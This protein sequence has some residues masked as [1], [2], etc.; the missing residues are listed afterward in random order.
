M[1]NLERVVRDVLDDLKE[2]YKKDSE[3]VWDAPAIRLVENGDN[4]AYV[5]AMDEQLIDRLRAGLSGGKLK[6]LVVG[7][8]VAKYSDKLRDINGQPQILERAILVSGRLFSSGQTYV[9]IVPCHQHRD[10]RN[11]LG[12]TIANAEPQKQE[13]WV[14]GIQ[15]DSLSPDSVQKVITPGGHVQFVSV[16]FGEETIFDSRKGDRCMLD[17]IIEGVLKTP[18]RPENV[19]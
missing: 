16:R 13:L 18:E 3:A 9:V 19:A 2:L 1:I 8:M 17:P 11:P 5:T 15:T 10:A 7:R 14:P 6:G 4:V 12:D